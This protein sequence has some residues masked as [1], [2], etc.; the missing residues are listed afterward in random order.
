MALIT[1][2]LEENKLILNA[3]GMEPLVIL[4]STLNAI[5]ADNEKAEEF[6]VWDSTALS[7]DLGTEAGNWFSEYFKEPG[8][9]L[10]YNPPSWRGRVLQD[11]TKWGF[12]GEQGDQ[13]GFAD[14]SPLNIL[15]IESLNWLSS[16]LRDH[17]VQG[18]ENPVDFRRFRPSIIV[19][20]IENGVPKLPFAEDTWKEIK[21]GDI[22][23]ET[24][25]QTHRC[26]VTTVDPATGVFHPEGEP[27]AL[28]QK[29]RVA[30]YDYTV[31]KVHGRK[32]SEAKDEQM[33][34]SFE[35]GPL[36]GVNVAALDLKDTAFLKVG[37]LL[38][39][40]LP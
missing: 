20:E 27:R 15:S 25:R 36:F 9:T 31:L 24:R 19:E 26:K 8:Y 14:F 39:V 13:T 34:K 29:Y 5:E 30:K 3:P 37:D 6:R 7:V 18:V 16:K 22:K 4:K 40:T 1:P 23:M 12:C 2:T 21:I 17:K 28:L 32:A 11:S 35:E 38:T 33:I 10:R